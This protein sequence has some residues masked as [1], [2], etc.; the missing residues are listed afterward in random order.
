M[1]GSVIDTCFMVLIG[2]IAIFGGVGLAWLLGVM[3]VS[4]WTD[5]RCERTLT[6]L[7]PLLI[8][9]WLTIMV[10]VM[11]VAMV[12]AGLEMAGLVT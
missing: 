12:V 4:C 9:G 8:A 5:W 6:N 7:V 10:G 2:S 1:T 11:V 3:L